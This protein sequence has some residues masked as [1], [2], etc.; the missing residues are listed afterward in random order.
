MDRLA[1]REKIRGNMIPLPTPFCPDW[2]VDVDALRRLVRRMLDAGYR[3]GNGVLLAG[4]AGGE[5]ANDA[6]RLSVS[7]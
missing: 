7:R 1:H 3:T 6:E 2:A 4:G 5:F